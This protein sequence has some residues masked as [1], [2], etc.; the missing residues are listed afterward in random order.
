MRFYVA[1]ALTLASFFGFA[2]QFYAQNNLS[3]KMDGGLSIGEMLTP[4]GSI[5]LFR[6]IDQPY[7]RGFQGIVTRNTGKISY[8]I[9][10]LMYHNGGM[11][12]G[13]VDPSRVPDPHILIAKQNMNENLEFIARVSTNFRHRT[14]LT[15]QTQVWEFGPQFEVEVRP[16]NENVIMSMKVAEFYEL[17]QSARHI[18]TR[19]EYQQVMGSFLL[20]NRRTCWSVLAQ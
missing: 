10:P 6:Y 5:Y 4:D 7:I 16:E 14:P 15:P 13:M 2:P 17:M 19:E 9:S 20:R 8:S 12:F 11:A 18:R 3:A 1:F